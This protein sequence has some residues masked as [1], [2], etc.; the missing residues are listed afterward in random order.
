[1]F[2]FDRRLKWH[3]SIPS[4]WRRQTKGQRGILLMHFSSHTHTHTRAQIQ[5]ALWSWK[6]FPT[7]TLWRWKMGVIIVL[8][9]ISSCSCIAHHL[10]NHHSLFACVFCVG[11]VSQ[12]KCSTSWA[13]CCLRSFAYP[14]PSLSPQ[15]TDGAE[16]QPHSHRYISFTNNKTGTNKIYNFFLHFT[17]AC[18]VIPASSTII[19]VGTTWLKHLQRRCWKKDVQP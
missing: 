12:R 10:T 16:A 7:V 18:L 11:R 15:S 8:I 1:M 6:C 2:P 4:G 17:E 14:P 19:S 3:I 5:L 13:T 9:I